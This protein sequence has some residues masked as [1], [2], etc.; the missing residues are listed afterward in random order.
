MGSLCPFWGSLV[1]FIQPCSSLFLRF[2]L[3]MRIWGFIWPR[4]RHGL[5]IPWSWRCPADSDQKPKEKTQKNPVSSSFP[6]CI[7]YWKNSISRRYFLCDLCF[8]VGEHSFI[9]CNCC[10]QILKV[11]Q[12]WKIPL[13]VQVPFLSVQVPKQSLCTH[14]GVSFKSWLIVYLPCIVIIIH[15]VMALVDVFGLKQHISCCLWSSL[16]PYVHGGF[17]ITH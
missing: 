14:V 5:E 13:S 11:E 1:C 4:T 6:L 17:I 7:F 9:G 15:N 8:V 10:T 12:A 3:M 16:T 2:Y